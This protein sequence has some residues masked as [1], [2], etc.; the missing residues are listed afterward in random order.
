MGFYQLQDYRIFKDKLS[1]HVRLSVNL[2]IV[3][4]PGV[5]VTHFVKK[6]LERENPRGVTYINSPGSKLDKFNILDL[7]F[8]KTPNALDEVTR[9]MKSAT[10]DQ[11]FAIVVN[12]PFLLDSDNYK[13][14]FL[15][16]HVYNTYYFGAG[17]R[18]YV[19]V[20]VSDMG[21]DLPK[22]KINK[23]YQ[24]SG[25]LGRLVKFLVS[26][27]DWLEKNAKEIVEQDETKSILRPTI[28]VV[29][30]CNDEILIKLRLQTSQLLNTYFQLHPVEKPIDIKLLPDLTFTE[31]GEKRERL[32]KTESLILKYILEHQG[33]IEKDKVAEFKW[34]EGSYDK[35]SDQ[36]VNKT[37]RRLDKK[38]KFYALKTL[39]EYGFKIIKRA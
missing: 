3:S 27:Q 39:P 32:T 35:F 31:Q 9:Y 14:S 30:K 7:D 34:G 16:S 19:E 13:R 15:A 10:L 36:A 20:Y 21:V 33:I 6:F 24:L 22:A 2:L 5:G 26:H 28:E 29:S 23:I 4:V 18:D 25:G 1:E 37:M 11:K 38:L 12:T 17:S 8:D